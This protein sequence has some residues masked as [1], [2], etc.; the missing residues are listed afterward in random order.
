MAAIGETAVT[1]TYVD[2]AEEQIDCWSVI[3]KDGVLHITQRMHSSL[4]D[5]H[6]PLSQV[7]HYTTRAY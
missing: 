1:I 3:A 4:D 7:R 2:G 5:K 6:I